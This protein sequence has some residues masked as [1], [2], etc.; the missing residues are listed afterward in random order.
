MAVLPSSVA[1]PWFQSSIVTR[2]LECFTAPAVQPA[3]APHVHRPLK[4]PSVQAEIAASGSG[5]AKGIPAGAGTSNTAEAKDVRGSGTTAVPQRRRQNA[6]HAQCQRLT[7]GTLA[8]QN[9]RDSSLEAASHKMRSC[10]SQAGLAM[11][12]KRPRPV[13]QIQN[14]PFPLCSHTPVETS[15]RV[16]LLR[17][18]GK[19]TVRLDTNMLMP[20]RNHAQP[21]RPLLVWQAL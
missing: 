9:E 18:S 10:V 20:G 6:C 14:K 19:S 5:G 16:G 4:Q 11:L 12:Q 3:S 17:T 1:L 2:L 8:P 21:S 13:C 7:C 15:G